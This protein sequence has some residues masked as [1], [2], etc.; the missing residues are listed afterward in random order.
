MPLNYP[1]RL[2]VAANR[3]KIGIRGGSPDI[4]RE[5]VEH[6]TGTLAKQL[7]LLRTRAADKMYETL[8]AFKRMEN[9]QA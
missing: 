1:Y 6:F 8:R 3:A 5:H 2:D 4:R 9:R 7:M